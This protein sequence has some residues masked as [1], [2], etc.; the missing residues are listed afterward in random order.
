MTVIDFTGNFG[1]ELE[2]IEFLKAIVENAL[3]VIDRDIDILEQAWQDDNSGAF[4][5]TQHQNMS[6][7]K[8]ANAKVQE[9]AN[10]YLNEINN[11]LRI[12]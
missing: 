11:I 7:L 10:N 12:Y 3:L 4:L 1:P 9:E 6:D 5:A 8:T 2:K